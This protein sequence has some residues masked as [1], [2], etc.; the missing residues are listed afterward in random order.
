MTRRSPYK[1]L[2]ERLAANSVTD[3]DTGCRLW[4]GS[5]SRDGY[6]RL[7]IHEAGMEKRRTVWAHRLSYELVVGE[8]PAG[9]DLD[10]RLELCPHRSCIEPAHLVPTDYYQH[11]ARTHFRANKP[12]RALPVCRATTTTG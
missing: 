11:R 5:V 10:H 4:T 1:S 6:G 7:C 9:H 8:I 2:L 12:T 3:P